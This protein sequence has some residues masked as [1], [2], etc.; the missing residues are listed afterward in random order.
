MKRRVV[1]DSTCD[2]PE[3]VIRSHNI[4][5]VPVY[6]NIG[7]KGYLDGVE[8]SRQ[9]FYTKLP[10]YEHHP[11]TAAPS[12]ETFLNVYQKLA[13]E[14]AEEILSI[15]IASS[16]S[17]TPEMAKSAAEGFDAARLS[18]FDS[19][20]LSSA[21][22]FMAE[23][24][25]EAFEQGKSLD[26]VLELLNEQA[27]RT[28]VVAG[29]DTLEFMRRSG[30]VSSLLAGLG[31]LLRLKPLLRMYDGHASSERVRTN[32]R[33]M[34]RVVG[35][36]EQSQPIQQIALLHTNAPERAQALKERLAP[37]LPQAD[38]P[39]LNIT[40]VIGVHIGPGAAG[41]A[42]VSQE[43]PPAAFLEQFQE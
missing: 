3:Q 5:V 8:L 13:Q 43:V 38:P 21:A 26:Q 4:E 16:L 29:L 35:Y 18:V 22:G 27:K 25:A 2:L 17:A 23:R 33:A 12:P 30:R 28:F 7:D 40:P 15:H 34:D 1:I 11:T 31:G 6:I 37:L 39:I 9:E 19:G 10:D 32:A 24:A 41:V 14:G 20:Q 42:W 36:V